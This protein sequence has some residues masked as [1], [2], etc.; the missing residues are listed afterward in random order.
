MEYILD[1]V[2]LLSYRRK[3][4]RA[5][6]RGLRG[7]RPARPHLVSA[8]GTDARRAHISRIC[9]RHYI[10]CIGIRGI[11]RRG[12]PPRAAVLLL[13]T[14]CGDVD[15]EQGALL[16]LYD[17]RDTR[18]AHSHCYCNTLERKQAAGKEAGD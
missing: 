18:S 5:R 1:C 16:S 10:V 12:R 14:E 4:V 3:L 6:V 11:I 9:A 8:A 2:K 7:A 15:V 13:R 17:R